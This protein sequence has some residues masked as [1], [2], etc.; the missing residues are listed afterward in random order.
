[1]F[2][3]LIIWAKLPL[4]RFISIVIVMGT[5]ITLL[6][7]LFIHLFIVKRFIVSWL[8]RISPIEVGIIGWILLVLSW[9]LSSIIHSLTSS[10]DIILFDLNLIDII[11]NHWSINCDLFAHWIQLYCHLLLICSCNSAFMTFPLARGNSNYFA[12]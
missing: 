2:N 4:I 11:I 9:S 1:M 10:I 6:Y 3:V 5:E 7:L 8:V 12:F